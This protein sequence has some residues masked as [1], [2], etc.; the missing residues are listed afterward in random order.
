MTNKKIIQNDDKDSQYQIHVN[1]QTTPHS[2]KPA[3][4]RNIA[5]PIYS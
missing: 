3:T 4:H 5:I 2:L 1:L